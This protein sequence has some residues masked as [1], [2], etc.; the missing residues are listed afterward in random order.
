V[1]AYLPRIIRYLLA[2]L[3][4]W[5]AAAQ[6]RHTA[7]PQERKSA[8]VVV[9]AEAPP[10]EFSSPARLLLGVPGPPADQS[11][12]PLPENTTGI[13]PIPLWRGQGKLMPIPPAEG[14]RNMV[15]ARN[16]PLKLSH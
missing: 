4:S 9:T 11:L 12:K 6:E 2:A 5:S 13:E 7:P 10:I 14:P 1:K 16:V 8:E 3:I 15:P